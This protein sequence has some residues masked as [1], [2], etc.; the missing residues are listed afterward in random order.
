MKKS[1]LYLTFV[2]FILVSCGKGDEPGVIQEP[3]NTAPTAPSLV[4]PSNN[5]VCID[6]NIVFEW[7]TSTDVEGNRITYV[8]E[9]AENSSFS[10]LLE[11]HNSFASS[12]LITLT[13]GEAFYW[14]IK[15]VD[16]RAAESGYSS[17][18]QFLTE[19]DGASNH[20][21]FAPTLVAPAL[22]SEI[23]GT[24]TTLSWS[25][26]D[27]D[28]DTLTYDVYLDTN[29]DPITLV[30]QDQSITTFDATNLSAASTYYFKV[31]VKDGKGGVSIGQVWSFTTK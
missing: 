30:S 23:D 17:V 18:S 9:I 20:L 14:R 12:K 28:G 11:T 27:V 15:A 29:S 7:N 24:S 8:L 31:V 1:Y 25:A 3:E 22:N 19:G 16:S 10:P 6:N 5:T 2:L 13:R 21:P 26:T 4:Y